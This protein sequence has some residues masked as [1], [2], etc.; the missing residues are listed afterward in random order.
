M[1]EG[2]SN[3]MRPLAEAE[4]LYR[5]WLAHLDEEFTHQQTPERRA[6]IVRDEL[7]EIYLGRPHGGRSSTALMTETAIY[8]LAESFDVRNVALDADFAE[9]V[10]PEKYAPRRPLLWFWQMF[11]RSPLGLNLWLGFRVRCMLGRHI[12]Q[13][14]GKGVKI[15]PDVRF[16]VGYNLTIEDNCTLGRGA[17]LE[18]GT[19]ELVVPQGT[20][21]E[22]GA[23][24]GGATRELIR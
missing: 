22:A 11:D 5:R 6:E 21:V 15:Y 20:T 8:V 3:A 10:D 12:F 19:G 4:S 7:Y 1:G 9:G 14:I 13:K 24:F 18:D 17:V 16:Q 23:R 2:K